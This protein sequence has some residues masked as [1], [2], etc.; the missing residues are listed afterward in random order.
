MPRTRKTASGADAQDVPSTAGVRY[1][2]GKE[3]QEM[4][5]DMPSPNNRAASPTPAPVPA[6]APAPAGGSPLSSLPQPG[7]LLA[8]TARPNEPVTT[9]LS[10]GPG[11]GP[12]ILPVNPTQSPTGKFLRDLATVTGQSR[13]ADL[14]RQANL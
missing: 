9:G 7:L 3:L 13:F 5:R 1:G 6:A 4:Q 2:E 14:A 11:A 10:S 12:E 8:P